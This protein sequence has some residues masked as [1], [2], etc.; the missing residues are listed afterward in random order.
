MRISFENADKVNGLL[1]I[2]VEEAD[3]RELV[4]KTLKDY[5]KKVNVP[6]FRPGQVP[7]GL[8]KRQYGTAVKAEEVNKLVGNEIYKYVQE[9]NIR[10]LGEPM[11]N[12]SQAPVDLENDAEMT[13]AFDI[14]IA[15]DFKIDLTGK[16]KLPYYQIKVDDKLIDQQVEAYA[17]RS[18]EYEKVKAYSATKHD[19]LR[20]DL[21]ELDENG[22]P[23]A[24]GI[25]VEGAVM[26]PEYIKV[27]EQK[28][29]FT[30][31][32]LNG[33]VTFNPRKAY[34]ENDTEISSLLKI[35]KAKVAEL[36][37]DFAYKI[38]E[39]SRFKKAEVDQALFDQIFGEGNVKSEE[40]FRQRIAEGMKP[41]LAADADYKFLLD[42]RKYCEKK[43]GD[44]TYP[45]AILKRVMLEKNK[46]RGTE[47]VEKNFEQSLNELSWH[48]IKEQLVEAQGIKIEQEDIA[49]TAKESAR[50]QF[51]QYGMTA[52]PEEYLDN[53]AS[54]MMKKR[55]NVEQLV[56]RALDIKLVEKLKSVVKLTEKEVSLDD[57]NKLMRE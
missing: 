33:T 35:D 26:M 9:N 15:P 23:K 52:V 45:E 36:T 4:E 1:T 25:R 38:T 2:T 31:A 5:R 44:L 11:P 8:V 27:S 12:E 42:L 6:G 50:A 39:I 18:G 55:E 32:K 7:M 53:Y 48:L 24:D 46:D 49:K 47:F 34:P 14:A 10:M 17:S 29:L 19:M 51:A 28:K 56:D 41:Q 3:Y 30:G 57:F 22:E 43:V 40:E 54:E 13:F 21:Q 16:D 20:G 37:S